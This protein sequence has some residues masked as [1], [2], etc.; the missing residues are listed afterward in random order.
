MALAVLPPGAA[1]AAPERVVLQLKWRH[2][3]QFAGYYAAVAN[4]YSHEAGFEMEL[5]EAVPERDPVEEVLAGRANFGVGTSELVFLRAQGKPVVVRAAIFQHSPLE[6]LA[7]AEGGVGSLHDLHDK[8][9]MM[10][11]QSAELRRDP[12]RV[13]AFRAASLRGWTHALAQ[14]EAVVDLI[15]GIIPRRRRASICF[16]R[17][18]RRRSS[19]TPG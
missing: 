4:G 11:P 10:E 8:L 18:R 5:R 6:L 2:Q 12:A 9:L 19:C 16:S 14:P 15:R 7:R 3:F 1:I 13:R 17:R